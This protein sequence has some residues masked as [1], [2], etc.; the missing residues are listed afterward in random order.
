M[1]MLRKFV[2]ANR[3]LSFALTPK[4]VL[5]GNVF[6]QYERLCPL[7]MSFPDV[8]TVIDVGAGKSWHFPQWCKEAYGVRLVGLDIDGAEMVGNAS[9]DEAIE[10]D[11]TQSIPVEP[12]SADLVTAYSGVEHFSDNHAF[13][14]HA[15]Q[16]LR[17]GGALIAQ[18]PNDLA[19]FAII[20]RLLPEKLKMRLLHALVPGSEGVLGFKI[21]YD[22]IRPSR[23]KTIAKDV[24]FEVEY[25][26]PGY[27]SS[28][29]FAAFTPIY[30]LSYL[31]DMLRYALGISEISSYSLFILRKPGPHVSLDFNR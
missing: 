20:N 10:C 11:V 14:K 2:T 16:A 8:K 5:Q 17:P 1:G 9:L 21:H 18:F 4:H 28:G 29:Y 25:Y 19:P 26:Y 30:M 23:F 27:Y 15:Y 31:Y 3:K 12:N 13:L 24:G 6:A 7:L 22:R